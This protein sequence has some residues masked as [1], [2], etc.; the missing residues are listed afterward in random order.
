MQKSWLILLAILVLGLVAVATQVT[1]TQ[2]ASFVKD[3]P[4]TGK[5]LTNVSLD[6]ELWSGLDGLQGQNASNCIHYFNTTFDANETA[7]NVTILIGGIDNVTNILCIANSSCEIGV[8]ICMFYA[9]TSSDN[10]TYRWDARLNSTGDDSLDSFTTDTVANWT[11]GVDFLD[12]FV[13]IYNT[14]GFNNTAYAS[15]SYIN[16]SYSYLESNIYV[17]R[18]KADVDCNG[19]LDLVETNDSLA[20]TTSHILTSFNLTTDTFSECNNT[21]WHVESIDLAGRSANSTATYTIRVD[22]ESPVLTGRKEKSNGLDTSTNNSW[23]RF[24][25]NNF[26]FTVLDSNLDSCELWLNVSSNHSVLTNSPAFGM[27]ALLT[28]NW[29]VW[30][31]SRPDSGQGN[32]NL[33]LHGDI[34]GF[35]QNEFADGTGYY[36]N[37]R[38]NDSAGNWGYL[39]GSSLNDTRT[40]NVDTTKPSS[41]ACELPKNDTGA[42]D[43]TP[44]FLWNESKDVNTVTYE[45]WYGLVGT[46]LVNI[47]NTTARNYTASTLPTNRSG[48]HYNWYVNATDQAGNSIN[49]TN[50]GLDDGNLLFS[51]F[52]MSATNSLSAGWNIVSWWNS[53]N[54]TL[55]HIG[56]SSLATYVSVYN[57]SHDFVTYVNSSST[58]RNIP[59]TQGDAVFIYRSTSGTWEGNQMDNYSS[60]HYPAF[61]FTNATTTSSGWNWFSVLTAPFKGAIQFK[62]LEERLF[63]R[64]FTG[65]NDGD[66]TNTLPFDAF[67]GN[68]NLTWAQQNTSL[69]YFSLYNNTDG[70][71]YPFVANRT[72]NNETEIFYGDV[73]AIFSKWDGLYIPVSNRTTEEF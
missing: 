4:A 65:Y 6:T 21:A 56:N 27:D 28:R 34:L 35:Y 46:T 7:G 42:N 61:N 63:A 2:V 38:C 43:L 23:T 62:Q 53:T 39:Y 59:V 19:N 25:T 37:I 11:F 54:Q 30:N 17:C 60:P 69:K 16:F 71:Y 57:G 1:W 48:A 14:T 49:G 68:Y 45:F 12:P 15:G 31:G 18:L 9:N 8:D 47:E 5:W 50:C 51:Y 40:F 44:T 72:F 10:L 70:L 73:V 41:F 58:N 36:Y 22:T 66:V 26:T 52:P 33:G 13:V 67:G 24:K 3:Q 32:P 20:D 64:N 55:G 29:T